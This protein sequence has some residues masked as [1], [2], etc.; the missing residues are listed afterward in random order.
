MLVVFLPF[1]GGE[2]GETRAGMGA[3]K[4]IEGCASL[5][6]VSVLLQERVAIDVVVQEMGH[7]LDA[8][9]GTGGAGR[10]L[11]ATGRGRLGR[12]HPDH[13]AGAHLEETWTKSWK[14]Y[15]S[16][17]RSAHRIVRWNRLDVPVPQI[18]KTLGEVVQSI[19][20]ERL[21]RPKN[22]LS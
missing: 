3:V 21:Q 4:T 20:L 13:S 7:H 5:G 12:R 16:I 1:V 14:R 11:H 17:H 18:I 15:R 19:T 9:Y 2:V 8:P 6:F 22:S 10:H